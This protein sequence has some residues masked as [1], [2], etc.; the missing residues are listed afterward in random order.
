MKRTFTILLV[1]LISVSLFAQVPQK[2]SYQAVIRDADN[3]LIAN[4]VVTMQISIIQ[5]D[6]DNGIVVYSEVLSPTSNSNGMVTIEIGGEPGFNSIDWSDGPYF[7]KTETDPTGNSNY[8]IAGISQLLTVPY[9]LHAKTAE[10]ISQAISETDPIFTEWDR[11]DGIII[12]EGQI[13]D[14]QDYIISE[15]DPVFS[16]AFDLEG[17]ITGDIIG[18]DGEKWVKLTADFAETDHI[19]SLANDTDPGF[20]SAEDKLKLNDLENSDGSETIIISG[21]DIIVNGSGTVDSPYEIGVTPGTGIGEMRYW[22]GSNWVAV[23]P[24][25][26]GTRLT[27]CN[28]VPTWGPC[29]GLATLNITYVSEVTQASAKIGIHIIS[30][31]GNEITERGVVY[32][33][34]PNPTIDDNKVTFGAGIGFFDAEISG[35]TGG[36]LYY[37]RAYA[38]T[39]EGIAYSDPEAFVAVELEYGSVQDSQGN[40]YKTVVIGNQEWFAENLRTTQ[41][42]NGDPIPNITDNSEWSALESGAYAVY[43]H[44]NIFSSAYGAIYNWYTVVDPR[45]ICP[46]GWDVATDAQ[47]TTLFDYVANSAEFVGATVGKA[48][49]SCRQINSPLGIECA[50]TDHPRWNSHANVFGTDN[51]GFGGLPGGNRS[52]DGAFYSLGSD[53]F[54]WSSTSSDATSAWRRVMHLSQDVFNRSAVNKKQGFYVRCVRPAP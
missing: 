24:G 28:G 43:N 42:N 26:S 8:T 5:G 15:T 39:D 1:S 48:L 22:D 4:Q 21:T 34:Y 11:S 17:A 20:M 29:P 2:M 45:E 52:A 41:Y 14:L 38:V 12:T 27:L 44:D 35:L 16:S 33:L 9:A 19:H 36:S 6:A 40:A 10:T 53:A 31:G 32:D 54:W 47:W 13:S 7:L 49:K 37:V 51:Y 25:E 23:A 50:V 18:F 30:D 46:A 3:N